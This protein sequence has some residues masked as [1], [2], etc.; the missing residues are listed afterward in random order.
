MAFLPSASTKTL[1]AYLTQKGREYVLSG[2]QLQFRVTQFSL[3]DDDVNYNISKVLVNDEYNKLPKGF[4]PDITGDDDDCVSSIAAGIYVNLGCR[5]TGDTS[6]TLKQTRDI[7]VGFNSTIY[8]A[9]APTNITQ[10]TFSDS[11]NITVSL[12]PPENDFDSITSN[13]I[14]NTN[15]FIVVTFKSQSITNVKIN[16]IVNQSPSLTFSN[17]PSLTLSLTFDKD[18]S[19]SSQGDRTYDSKI[20]MEIVSASG[21][22]L[23]S[24]FNKFTYNIPLT[25]KGKGGTTGS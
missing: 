2:D 18:N 4:V 12:S 19:I 21:A 8:N 15:F 11:T 3:H 22:L 17:S 24:G 1:Y 5:I 20:E 23:K 10:D 13:E 6:G 9:P 16:G 25:I 7:Y 14:S